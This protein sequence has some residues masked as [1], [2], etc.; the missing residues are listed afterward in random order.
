M[1]RLVLV[2]GAQGQ[3]RVAARALWYGGAD[4]AG[5]FGEVY[6]WEDRQLRPVAQ[7]GFQVVAGAIEAEGAKVK[8]LTRG[9]EVEVE[10]WSARAPQTSAKATSARRQKLINDTI[11]NGSLALICIIWTI[12]TIGLL[13]SSFRTR[14]DIQTSGWWT[15]FPHR[16]YV[17]VETIELDRQTPLD[18][19]IQVAGVTVTDQQLRDGYVLPDGRKIMWESRRR[20]TVALS[21]LAMRNPRHRE[22]KQR[23][24]RMKM[25]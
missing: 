18:Q 2:L 21:G 25:T 7:P 5:E 9:A 3:A 1:K 12:P 17:T 24:R 8:D 10:D 6:A 13:I 11:V 23:R 22:R 15:V 14:E 19:P 16:E 20:R 4:L